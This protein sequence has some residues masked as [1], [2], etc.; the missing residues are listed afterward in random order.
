M[1]PSVAASNTLYNR[2][3]KQIKG[4]PVK[5]IPFS[6]IWIFMK[7]II[8]GGRDFCDEALIERSI[9]ELIK[10]GTIPRDFTL[11]CGMARGADITAYRLCKRKGSNIE[12]FPAQWDLYGKSAGHRR[13]REMG[14]N[15]DMLLAFWDGESRGTKG[16]IQYMKSLGK[17]VV[18]K[19]YK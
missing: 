9:R 13:N 10:E 3:Y 7:L 11:V 5:D 4:S 16:M 15:A 19:M 1:S 14:D 2:Q 17:P 6:F 12:E 8:A 18:I